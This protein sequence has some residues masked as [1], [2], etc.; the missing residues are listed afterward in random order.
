MGY[1][2][3]GMRSSAVAMVLVRVEAGEGV[4]N[5]IES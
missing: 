5:L 2:K 3:A 1:S 4:E